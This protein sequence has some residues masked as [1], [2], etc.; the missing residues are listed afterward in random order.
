[1]GIISLNEKRTA[2][3][4][5]LTTGKEVSYFAADRFEL[6]LTTPKIT[7][8][9]Y[10]RAGL[11][12][13]GAFGV[14]WEDS[15]GNVSDLTFES[16]STPTFSEN[17]RG[18]QTHSGYTSPWSDFEIDLTGKPNGRPVFYVRR[19]TGSYKFV[20]DV[21]FDDIVFTSQD[22]TT[23]N[24]D[25]SS[26]TVRNAGFW[27]KS[28]YNAEATSYTQA[29]TNYGDVTLS[30]IANSHLHTGLVFNFHQ[31]DTPSN[32]TGPDNAADN[33]SSTYYLYYESTSDGYNNAI[34]YLTWREYRNIITGAEI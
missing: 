17:E 20:M 14:F 34:G 28:T 6:P 10:W 26:N 24:L 9:Y 22:T 18:S 3:N 4:P 25:P 15:S 13:N 21:C 1:M 33:N 5:K 23:I 12:N 16:T 31:G 19:G 2:A 30:T 11:A 7:G 8:H 27:M 29:K 32:Y